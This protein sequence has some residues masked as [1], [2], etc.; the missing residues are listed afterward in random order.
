MDAA[1][2]QLQTLLQLEAKH[3]ELLERLA[4]LDQRVAGVLAQCQAQ[5]IANQSELPCVEDF[6]HAQPVERPGRNP[7]NGLPENCFR[8]A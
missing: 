1:V 8:A 3:D 5:A 2:E 7:G 6:Q 4:E